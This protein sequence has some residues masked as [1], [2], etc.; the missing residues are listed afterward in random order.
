MAIKK[1]PLRRVAFFLQKRLDKPLSI[2]YKKSPV[3]T[4]N[5]G[6]H[7]SRDSRLR[8]KPVSPDCEPP[9]LLGV[10]FLSFSVFVFI[11]IMSDYSL[12]L[13]SI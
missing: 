11:Y 6:D 5:G 12:S 9:I 10:L 1:P 2:G 13:F 7:M 3:G 4:L 8:L